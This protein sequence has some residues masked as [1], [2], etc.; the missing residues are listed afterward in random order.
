MVHEKKINY[1]CNYNGCDR[2]FYLKRSYDNHIKAE[3]ITWN[4]TEKPFKCYYCSK[5]FTQSYNVKLHIDTVHKKLRPYKC[6]YCQ[7]S[8]GRKDHLNHHID[9]IHKKIKKYGCEYCNRRFG[10]S[11]ELK[12]HISIHT[13]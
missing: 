5:R 4:I 2:G 11:T 13:G 10:G 3:H 8:F 12:N 9:V 1:E 6:N 7:H